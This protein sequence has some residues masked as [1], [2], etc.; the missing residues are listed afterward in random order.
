MKLDELSEEEF[1]DKYYNLFPIGVKSGGYPVR[2]GRSNCTK[3]MK[4]FI[5]DNPQFTRAI[6][7]TATMNYLTDRKRQNYAYCKLAHY[8]ISKDGDSMLEGWCE[9]VLNGLKEDNQESNKKQ[10]GATDF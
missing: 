3:K 8:F 4:K 7:I 6:I 10:L 5:Q 1:I 9:A 2:S